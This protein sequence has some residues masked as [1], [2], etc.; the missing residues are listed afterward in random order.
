MN[1]NFQALKKGAGQVGYGK[2]L[3]PMRDWL[4]LVALFIVLFLGSIAFNVWQLSKVTAG[5]ALSGEVT[6]KAPPSLTLDSLQTLFEDRR[7]EQARYISEYRFI[8]PSL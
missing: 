2:Q 6:A 1:L 3:R 8:D 5:E 7:E 4:F